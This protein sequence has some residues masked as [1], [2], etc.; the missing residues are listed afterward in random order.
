M[1]VSNSKKKGFTL[2]EILIVLAVISLVILIG[3]SSYGVVRK[4]VK[5]DIAVNY[6]QST[7][8]EARDKT[9]AGYYQE[10]DSKI[11]DATSLC[12][13]FIVKEGEFVTPLTANYDRLKQEGSQCD[14]QNAKQL[15][16]IDKEKDI[17]VK[18]LLFYG[19]DIGE[20]M[21][22]F[23][24]P[25]DGNIE[26]E[27][28]AVV[29]GNPELRIVIGYPDSDEDLNKREVIF[30]VLTGSVYSQTFVQNE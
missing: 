17:V 30:N 19:N 13:G 16:L 10:N 29:Q 27:K 4:K 8:V 6:L 24:A 18:D 20:E 26:F 21:Q 3:V 25:P 5:L 11:A 7:I 14:I 2:V 22:I 15:L 9:R 1:S 28:P 23:F 12:F